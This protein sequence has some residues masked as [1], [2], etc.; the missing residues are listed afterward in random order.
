[1]S[2]MIQDGEYAG[3]LEVLGYHGMVRQPEPG[4]IIAGAFPAKP[5]SD[6]FVK[7]EFSSLTPLTVESDGRV[8]GHIASWRQSHIGM[9]GSIK[10]PRSRSR[11]AF[12]QTGQ[13]ETVEGDLINVGQITL[14]GG[15]APL[16]ASVADT[17]AHYDNTRS[18]VMDVTVFEDRYGIAVAGALRPNVSDEQLREIRAS[19]VSGDWRP[20]NGNMELVAV[21]AVNVPGFPIPRA[22]VASGTPVALVAAGTEALVELSI[23]QPS[24][25]QPERTDRTEHILAA[26]HQRV[27]RLEKSIAGRALENRSI[28]DEAIV[29]AATAGGQKAVSPAEELR[30]RVHGTQASAKSASSDPRAELRKRVHKH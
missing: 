6:W 18:A 2:N 19:A 5:P 26:M 10:P 9:A 1:V 23:T 7:P 29:A 4:V 12:F 11:Y 24:Q 30:A 20:I 21:C 8:F 14:S 28:L 25:A 17:I 22:R 3:S 15:H 13:V 27:R 16:N